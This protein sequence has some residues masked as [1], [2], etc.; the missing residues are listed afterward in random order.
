MSFCLDLGCQYIQSEI[1]SSTGLLDT[2]LAISECTTCPIC[3]RTYD[4][5]FLLVFWSSVIEF[6]EWMTATS[7]LPF[8]VENKL[9][10]L[11]VLMASLYWKEMIFD[12][13]S[14]LVTQCNIDTLFLLLAAMGVLDIQLT[15]D[16]CM[17]IVGL[18]GKF[19][20]FNTDFCVLH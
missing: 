7:K 10:I 4:K 20:Q 14:G 11:S 18:E 3:T 1:Y 13:S 2:V 6:I 16:R 12:K 15:L 19:Q 5:D 8:I 17:W 9:Q